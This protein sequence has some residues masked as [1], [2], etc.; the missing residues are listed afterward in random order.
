LN[1]VSSDG[2]LVTGQN[3]WSTWEAAES[4]IRQIGYEPKE[5]KIT[6]EENAITVLKTYETDGYA[7]AYEAIDH[8]CSTNPRSIDI[9]LLAVHSIVAAMGLNI[10][11]SVELIQLLRFSNS[12]I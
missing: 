4:V 11:K 6:A 9:E 7:K 3:P 10:S 1:Q 8:F 5:R 2:K 12:F